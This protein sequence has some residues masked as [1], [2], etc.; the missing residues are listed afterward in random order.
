L[1][2]IPPLPLIIFIVLSLIFFRKGNGG[3]TNEQ[4]HKQ[5]LFSVIMLP[6]GTDTGNRS[7]A[8]KFP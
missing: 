5:V 8:Q 3:I 7:A 4:Y 1:P 6:K 2:V